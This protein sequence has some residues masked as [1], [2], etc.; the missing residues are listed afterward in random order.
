MGCSDAHISL[1][2]NSRENLMGC[3]VHISRNKDLFNF[4]RDRKDEIEKEIGGQIEWVDAAVASRIKINK[5]VNKVFDQNESE[6]YFRWLYEKT[7]LFQN[8]F[9]KLIKQFR[10]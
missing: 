5:V 9:P 1:T 3:E 8:V 10:N 2:V 6:I 7:I 4:L